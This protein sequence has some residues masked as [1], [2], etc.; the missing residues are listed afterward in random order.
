MTLH[1]LLLINKPAGI[2]SH[3][4]VARTRRILQTKS[5]G[6]SG[7]LDPIASGLMVLLIGEGTKLSQYIL[8]RNKAYRVRAQLGIRTDTLDTTG[9]VLETN[10]GDL[11]PPDLVRHEALKLAGEFELPIPIFSAAKVEGRKLYEYAREGKEVE[12]PKKLMNFF[13]L[14][15]EDQGPDWIDVFI[16][17]SKGSFIRTWVSI[18]GDNLKV[19]AAMSRLERVESMPYSLDQAITFEELEAQI[20]S[21]QPLEKGFVPMSSTLGEAKVI[22]IKGQ[23]QVMMGNGLISHDLRTKL[24]SVF[25]PAKDDVIKIL[26]ATTGELLALIGLDP[27][28]GFAIRRVFRY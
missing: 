24:I 8:E 18:L 13:D 19:G 26:S 17:C 23:D 25:Q 16:R 9:T 4:V 28:K 12:I 11:P 10:T 6:H 27:G 2:T 21:G 7:T 5:V 3:D 22:R 20:G 14:K 15:I 1:G